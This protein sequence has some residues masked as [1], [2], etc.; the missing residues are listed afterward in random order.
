[1]SRGGVE[2]RRLASWPAVLTLTLTLTLTYTYTY[3]PLHL[4]TLTAHLR[5]APRP[6]STSP[7]LERAASR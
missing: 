7:S 5:E 1:M 2:W 4:L 6:G 3:L